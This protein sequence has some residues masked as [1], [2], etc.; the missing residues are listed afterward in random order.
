MLLLL[1]QGSKAQPIVEIDFSLAMSGL[2]LTYEQFVDLCIL[3]GCDYCCSIKGVGPKTALKLIRQHKTIEA[4]LAHI[5]KEKKFA[6]PKD[7]T[8]YRM[9]L[10]P[11]KEESAEVKEEEKVEEKTDDKSM[12][13][14]VAAEDNKDQSD[15]QLPEKEKSE[16]VPSG[17]NDA[18][19]PDLDDIDLV[20]SDDEV[21]NTDEEQE[22]EAVQVEEDEQEQEEE[23]GAEYVTVEPLFLRA[24][25]LFLN[26]DVTPAEV[27]RIKFAA[28][29]LCKDLVSM[30]LCVGGRVKV[31]GSPGG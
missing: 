27:R 4:V 29:F 15:Q 3:C 25:Q 17:N 11:L 18:P 8:Q 1:L 23:E 9:K 20:L 26:C 6:V 2:D 19:V 24:R 7:F 28:C 22:P 31:G 13:V 21:Y 12:D 14:E 10:E 16:S 5:K 30:L